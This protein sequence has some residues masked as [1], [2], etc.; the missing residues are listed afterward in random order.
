VNNFYFETFIERDNTKAVKNLEAFKINRGEET[1]MLN[2]SRNTD[3]NAVEA[4]YIRNIAELLFLAYGILDSEA[5]AEDAVSEVIEKLINLSKSGYFNASF[6]GE[7]ELLGFVRIALRNICYD[8]LRRRKRK[9]SIFQKIGEAIPIWTR[10]EA[11][12][13]FQKEAI[14][15]MLLE[16]SSREKQIFVLY[17]QGFRNHEITTRL[18]IS[19]L[20]VRNTLFNA[21]KRIRTIWNKFMR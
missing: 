15:L 11:F 17:N 20:T 8:I 7:G 6:K 19:E 5:E 10:P 18:G 2:L 1:Q 4:F 12:D 9:M 13:T 21:K 16:L 14:E 3:D